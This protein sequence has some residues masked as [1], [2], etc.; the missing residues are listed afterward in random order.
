M[1][2]KA[3]LSVYHPNLKRHW[4]LF[5]IKSFIAV[6]AAPKAAADRAKVS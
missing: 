6:T 3:F 5:F 4:V 2:N 1:E